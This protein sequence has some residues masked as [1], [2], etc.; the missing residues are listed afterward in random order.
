MRTRRLSGTSW[1]RAEFSEPWQG[2]G[3]VQSPRAAVS[4]TVTIQ[5]GRVG[6]ANC[7]RSVS[8][9]RYAAIPRI[10]FKRT[11]NAA[12]KL[13]DIVPGPALRESARACSSG[14]AMYCACPK[15]TASGLL[16]S[17]PAPAANS[18]R[19]VIFCL[20]A[21]AT[22][23]QRSSTSAV[24]GVCLAFSRADLQ[25]ARSN[26]RFVGCHGQQNAQ[27]RHRSDSPARSVVPLPMPV[28]RSSGGAETLSNSDSAKV[29][30]MPRS[31]CSDTVRSKI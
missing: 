11:L 5:A 13:S 15:M 1:Q 7:I 29:G 18:A 12:C 19:A 3:L 31:S 9:L 17:W 10:V 24:Q 25:Q 23:A 26:R 20:Q 2:P 21:V 4:R 30:P 6:L 8:T 27:Q 28:Q 14:R 22:P 16:I